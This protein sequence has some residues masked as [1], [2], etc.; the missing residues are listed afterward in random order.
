MNE[1]YD[2]FPGLFWI[3]L[4]A[5][6][7]IGAYEL[8]LGSFHE[9]GAGLIP[10]LIGAILFLVSIPVVLKSVS[11][12]R[13]VGSKRKEAAKLDRIKLVCVAG[14]LFAYCFL[15]GRLG[16][17]LSTTLL[18]L[19]LFKIAGTRKWRFVIAGSVLTAVVTYFGFTFLGLRFPRGIFGV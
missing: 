19:F 1:K 11:R 5:F 6:A 18:L 12:I 8:G 16:Y 15:I 14:S 10:F 4:S 17:L 2:I 3:A 7:M 9:P 13:D